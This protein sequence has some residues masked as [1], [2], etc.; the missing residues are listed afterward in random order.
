MRAVLFVLPIVAALPAAA[1]TFGSVEHYAIVHHEEGPTPALS[2]FLRHGIGETR[3]EVFVFGRGERPKHH[4]HGA[5]IGGY[6]YLVADGIRLGIGAGATE[7]LDRRAGIMTSA[8]RWGF[9]S[10]GILDAGHGRPWYAYTVTSPTWKGIGARFQGETHIG[11]GPG[12]S[13][14]AKKHFTFW[15]ALPYD[16]HYKSFNPVFGIG[17]EHHLP[18]GRGEH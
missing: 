17:F 8:D 6:S 16:R 3:H 4:G 10:F 5:V 18:F 14:T 9:R 15:A 2:G 7:A 12:V 11:N 1:Q 13:Y